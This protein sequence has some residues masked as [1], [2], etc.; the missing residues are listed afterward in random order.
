MACLN[1]AVTPKAVGKN[2]Y[3]RHRRRQIAYGRW[4]PH[5][6]ATAARTHLEHLRRHGHGRVTIGRQAGVH[7]STIHR[8][9]TG[10]RTAIHAHVEARILAVTT[11]QTALVDA[12][13]A[14]RRLQ[15]LVADGW[16]QTVLA[17][18]IGWKVNNLTLVVSGSRRQLQPATYRAIYDLYARLAG[19]PGPDTYGGRRARTYAAKRGWPACDFWDDDAIDDPQA[20]PCTDAGP[21]VDLVA[22]EQVLAGRRG[23]A[24][25]NR[26]E[27]AELWRTWQR[28]RR[29]RL[30]DA[31]SKSFQAA[32][33]LTKAQVRTIR[34]HAEPEAA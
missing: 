11:V 19:T 12:T 18:Q 21:D 26:A 4:K 27:R 14:R 22:V 32:H 23:I 9:V 6:D 28:R 5:V 25:L 29:G 3:E 30:E 34:R 33:G 13:G 8:I 1:P 20:G 7:P 17:E 31:G 10:R 16:P 15:A 24:D 2:A